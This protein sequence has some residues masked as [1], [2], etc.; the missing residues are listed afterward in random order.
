M[1]RIGALFLTFVIIAA[2]MAGMWIYQSWKDEKGLFAR[3]EMKN[4]YL[5]KEK[6]D[7]IQV[8]SGE[9]K[10]ECRVKADI[11]EEEYRGIGDVTIKE[12]KV[13]K[14]VKK[15]EVIT[16]KVLAVE[17]GSVEIENYGTLMLDEG[18][19]CFAIREG[20]AGSSMDNLTIGQTDVDFA[21][22]E[23]KIC[24]ILFRGQTGQE[25]ILQKER[26]IR[27]I[28]KTENFQ[29]Y[30]HAG[31]T[32]RGTKKIYVKQGK[33]KREYQP[34]ESVSF[35]PDTMKEKRVSVSSEEGGRIEVSSLKRGQGAPLYRGEIEVVKAEGGLHLINDLPLEE[36]LYGV[37]PSEMPAEYAPEALKAQAVCARS[38][39]VRHINNN[40]LKDLGAHVDDS[41]SYQV[42]N[43]TVEDERCNQAVD[44]TKGKKAYYEG[45]I[46]S[47]YFFSTSCGVTTSAKD[48]TFS[49]KDV[50]YLTGRLQE[51]EAVDTEKKE[52]AKLVSDTF[53]N[54]DLFRK[55][56]EEDRAV[57]DKSQ[58][59]YR[60]STT[61]SL[62]DI[63][64][65][66][67]TK[68]G[69]RCQAA[70]EKI[71]IRQPDGTYVSGQIDSVGKLKRIRIKSRKSGGVVYMAVIVGSDAT[72]RVYSEYNIRTLI[73]NEN[74]IVKKNDG[75][76][77]SGMT[78]LPSGFFVLDKEGDSYHI[79]GGGFGHGT[80]MS[81]TG[82]NELAQAGKNCEEIMAYYFDGV[83]IRE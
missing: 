48:V 11:K 44:A 7:T 16:G 35:S 59:W 4:V 17:T 25:E 14:L 72:V 55:F 26:N 83:E 61:I 29:G 58:P 9:E 70:G 32:L 39:A 38:Y 2:S 69:K 74:A 82:A 24:G 53:G 10:K 23:G 79:R 5:V 51:T 34:G 71:Q 49:T 8:Y 21:V 3:K 56:L 37:I 66:I 45:K 57:L 50:P 40:R 15:P 78:M 43:N 1:K 12:N 73:F 41:V 6:G 77:V 28:L 60:W 18:Y 46:A 52:R 20:V 68:I 13:E 42:Y 65:N 47:T 81:Q 33:N 36:Y 67:N 64:N 63:E 75:K 31:V 22:A 62:G 19:R 76:C 80:G 27:V 54:E 30:E